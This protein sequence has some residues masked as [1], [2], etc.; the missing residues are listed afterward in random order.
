[1]QKMLDATATTVDAV[2]NREAVLF[3]PTDIQTQAVPGGSR[4]WKRGHWKRDGDG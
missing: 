2:R 1:M 3:S 4:G